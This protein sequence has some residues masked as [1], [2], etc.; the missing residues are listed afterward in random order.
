MGLDLAAVVDALADA[1]V[2]VDGAWCFTIVNAAAEAYLGKSREQLLGQNLWAAFPE[3]LGTE[4]ERGLRRVAAGGRAELVA[5]F[6]L[7]AGRSGEANLSPHAQGLSILVRNLE[8]RSESEPDFRGIV[9]ASPSITYIYDCKTGHTAYSNDRLAAALGYSAEEMKRQ[10]ADFFTL[11]FIHPDD[12]AWVRECGQ[13]F[14]PLAEGETLVRTMRLRHKDG[15]WRWLECREVIFER[16]ANGAPSTYLGTALDITEQRLS[17]QELRNSEQRLRS[18]V[19]STAV[20]VWTT[21]PAGRFTLSHASWEAY[22]GQVVKDEGGSCWSLSVHPDDRERIVNAWKTALASGREYYAEG[23]L[24][25]NASQTWRQF[26]ARGLPLRNADGTVREWVGMCVD[27]E[28]RRRVE[29]QLRERA[30]EIET[31]MSVMPI[32]IVKAED[33]AGWKITC[34][35]AALRMTR[36]PEGESPS[37]L[38]HPGEGPVN[39]HF[40]YNGKR[41]ATDELPM[42]VALRDGVH[43]RDVEMEARFSDGERRNFY[44]YASPLFNDEHEVRGAFAAMVDITDRARTERMLREIQERFRAAQEAS[45]VSFNIWR[46][47][48]DENGEIVDFEWEYA[49]PA[50]ARMMRTLPSELERQSLRARVDGLPDGQEIFERYRH[51]AETGEPNESENYYD[52]HGIRGWYRVVV[53]RVEG[54]VAVSFHDISELKLLEQELRL[55]HEEFAVASRRTNEA[56]TEIGRQLEA[57]GALRTALDSGNQL[58]VVVALERLRMQA[59]E[60]LKN[61]E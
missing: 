11:D 18:L 29:R 26:E 14:W 1:F 34:N 19:D 25:H 32:G 30:E 42:R 39:H 44:V 51:V 52:V 47:V 3:V 28:D 58:D 43:V 40:Y 37:Q 17:E 56:L 53:V 50:S 41:M 21:D 8:T 4:S 16:D 33:A 27:V 23:R 7:V 49:N 57:D 60:A 36:T 55:C 15:S 61:A 38:R 54:G 24:W 13:Q 20:V 22:T 59:A 2:A 35:P 5:N 9:Q 45:P 46:S 48:F 12:Q 6:A 10:P 31:L